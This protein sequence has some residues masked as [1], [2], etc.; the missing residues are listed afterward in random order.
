MR[1]SLPFAQFSTGTMNGN[2][3]RMVLHLKLDAEER[4]QILD[5]LKNFDHELRR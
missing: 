2:I 4:R 3:R 5:Q 1:P